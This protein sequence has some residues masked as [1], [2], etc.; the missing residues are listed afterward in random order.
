MK[1]ILG[2][3]FFI[4]EDVNHDKLIM[5]SVIKRFENADY[6]ILNLESPLFGES[7][8][9][10]IK[11][12]G[13]HLKGHVDK[14]LSVL[15]RLGI[16]MVTL[17]NNHI[18]DY[19]EEGVVGTIS[20]LSSVGIEYIGAGVN[21]AEARSYKI[22]EEDGL[23]IAIL[24][25]AE[26]EW[27]IADVNDAGANPLDII[28][29]CRQIR[30]ASLRSDKVICIIH[31]GHEYFNYPSPRMVKQSE[32]YVECG[33]SAIVY[34][35]THCISGVRIHKGAPIFFGLGNFLFTSNSNYEGWYQGLVIEL[36]VTNEDLINYEIIPVKQ[37]KELRTLEIASE[38]DKR[39][40]C[41]EFNFYSEIINNSNQLDIKWIEF[42]AIKKQQ[43]L[44]SLNP[45]QFFKNIYI[46]S[47]LKKLS[48][49]R[50]LG[51]E[52]I[53]INQLHILRCESHREIAEKILESE[54][55]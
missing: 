35:H 49:D 39:N 5:D 25:F 27:S 43:Y 42:C 40:I 37:D 13:P 20:N 1:I 18:L 53:K 17:A 50:L 4:S 15:K 29:N 11:K 22:I 3:D 36:I 48:I 2:G 31:G 28:E 7:Q 12:V 19:G 44:L 26:N 6:R 21:L 16:S 55:Q 46:I 34:H 8:G 54:I 33:A 38:E 45:I 10:K 24:N 32:F 52:N 47:A 30:E 41:N 23:K 9:N 51:R 14:T